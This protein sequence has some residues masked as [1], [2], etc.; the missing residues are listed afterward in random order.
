MSR[1]C[2]ICGK[3]TPKWMLKTVKCVY[4]VDGQAIMDAE[5]QLCPN[6]NSIFAQELFETS[7]FPAKKSG[8]YTPIPHHDR[9]GK[10]CPDCAVPVGYY[11]ENGCD[12]E[13]CPVC[14]GQLLSCGHADMVPVL[15]GKAK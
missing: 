6:C 1:I 11:H 5:K 8:E 3:T 10:V 7:L 12:W 2:E 9:K 15:H 13:R 14:G 4:S